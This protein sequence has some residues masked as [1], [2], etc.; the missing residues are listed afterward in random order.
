DLL[1]PHRRE[2]IMVRKAGTTSFM[3]PGGKPEAGETAEE[4]IVRE[5]EEGLG[6]SL[7]RESRRA[8]GSF[9]AVAANEADHRVIGDVFCYEGLPYRL[10]VDDIR[11]LA[12]I[13]EAGWFPIDP[14]PADTA[15][16]QFAPLTRNEVIP[17]LAR[18]QAQAGG[19]TEAGAGRDPGPPA[20]APDHA[21]LEFEVEG[22]QMER[23]HQGDGGD[24]EAE[25]DVEDSEVRQRRRIDIAR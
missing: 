3:L 15:D 17:A 1:H 25:D 14:L 20:P 5:I 6:L 8:L 16:R 18:A 19:W 22:D 4:T 12:E 10:Y 21:P 2:L 9:S 11:H 13:A 7:L 24:E 23:M